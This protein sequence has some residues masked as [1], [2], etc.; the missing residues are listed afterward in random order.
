MQRR[1][2]PAS[3]FKVPHALIA[4]Q[5]HLVSDKT[6]IKW[7]GVRRDFPGVERRSD[8]RVGDQTIGGLGLSAL[9]DGDRPRARAR[10]PARLSL[11]VG[12][13]HHDVTDFWLNGDLQVSPAEQVA[14][15]RR[16]F[17]YDLPVDRPTSTR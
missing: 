11:R 9:R 8:A 2:L 13:I 15:L 14:F 1:T 6:V 17:T 10:E 7:D 4:L 12:D 5:T 16:M 3:T